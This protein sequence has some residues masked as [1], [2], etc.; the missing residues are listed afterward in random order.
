MRDEDRFDGVNGINYNNF[1]QKFMA[2]SD[3]E[4]INYLDVLN[5]LPLWL[6][7]T[8]KTIAEAKIGADNPKQAVKEIWKS[9]DDFFSMFSRS[10]SEM[11]DPIVQKPE[12]REG[13]MEALVE[14]MA[15]LGS[16]ESEARRM[17]LERELDLGHI[18]SKIVSRRI[19]HLAETFF[20][21]EAEKRELDEE[22]RFKFADLQRF[23]K[24]KASVLK[25]TGKATYSRIASLAEKRPPPPPQ[26]RTPPQKGP[27][28]KVTCRF[29]QGKH[30]TEDCERLLNMGIEE[31]ARILNKHGFCFKC[32]KQGHKR[33]D[34]KE[35]PTCAKC[36][37]QGHQLLLHGLPTIQKRK[38]W[39]ERQA[40][41]K[42]E[43]TAKAEA[44]AKEEAKTKTQAS[45]EQEKAAEEE[46][47]K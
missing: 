9:L 33:F 1:K 32:L 13:D 28:Y 8:P 29:C 31:R 3:V 18:I 27:A 5:E 45:S 44:K 17:G 22:F 15:E 12:V 23:L 11:I 35:N 37:M 36:G 21:K 39:E 43:A 10:I 6:N 30:E 20:T 4:G 46:A 14:L 19:P 38:A 24:T 34:C 16:V 25:A 42:A 47:I 41:A 26:Q 2:V 40:K 7:G